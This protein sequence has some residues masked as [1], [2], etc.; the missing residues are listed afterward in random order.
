[1]IL[2][3]AKQIRD[4]QL[5][6]S[7]VWVP[8]IFP[9]VVVAWFWDHVFFAGHVVHG[10]K[11]SET[12]LIAGIGRSFERVRL[13]GL[14]LRFGADHVFDFSQFEQFTE[15]GGVENI[16]AESVRRSFVRSS[17]KVTARA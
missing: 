12:H 16:G 7:T 10:K 3:G 13:A 2:S 4:R 14:G 9:E 8:V 6:P 5:G 11:M 1:M 15:F 17:C